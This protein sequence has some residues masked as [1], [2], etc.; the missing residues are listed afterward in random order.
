MPACL[1]V[2]WLE[3]EQDFPG[4]PL[5]IKADNS[6]DLP[7]SRNWSILVESSIISCEIID[8]YA[9][10]PGAAEFNLRLSFIIPD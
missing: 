2:P 5:W 3:D 7:S 8:I 10:F 6:T 9:K 1:E 4:I